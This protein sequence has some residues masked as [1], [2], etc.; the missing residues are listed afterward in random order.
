[1]LIWA[2]DEKIGL[3][4]SL[5]QIEDM[6]RNIKHYPYI[7][8]KF[9]ALSTMCAALVAATSCGGGETPTVV[10]PTEE[11]T[12]WSDVNAFDTNDQATGSEITNYGQSGQI[13]SVVKYT[14]DKETKESVKTEHIIYQ[15]GKPALGKS[16]KA[17]GEVE[18]Y[19]RFT[20]NENGLLQEELV[21]TYIE[22]LKRIAPSKRY[23]YEY[24][25]N[26]DVTSIKEQNTTPKGWITEYEWTYKYDPQARVVER[27]DYTGE[28]KNRKQSCQYRWKYE[29]GSNMTKQLD[30][31]FYDI[32][33]GRLKHDSK[34]LYKYN[35]A[36]Q[37]TEALVIRHKSNA[38]RDEINSRRFVYEYNKA[39]QTT[40]IYE[41]KW[42]NSAS[43]WN[44]VI[45]THMEYDAAGQLAKWSSNKFT[46]KGLKIMHEVHTRNAPADRPN[47]APAAPSLVIKPVI[48]LDE[49]HLTSAE[50]D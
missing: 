43:E 10:E 32:K 17:N 14:V 49:K 48:N 21:E 19:N 20:Y 41:E 45:S 23:V 30:Y 27:A 38:K 22:G 12:A 36:G 29:E 5:A 25:V 9:F 50:E 13:V 34:T 8:K 33:M 11:P 35:A 47:V 15:N 40:S 7:M 2:C 4:F 3:F 16:L 6:G 39:G 44:E 18:G 31:L 1:M 42:N 26:G 46:N 28:G 24:D 37:V